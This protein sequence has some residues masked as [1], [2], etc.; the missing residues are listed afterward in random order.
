MK[1][2]RIASYLLLM[3]AILLGT[4]DLMIVFIALVNPALLIQV[5]VIACVVIYSFTSFNFLIKGIDK[6][7]VFRKRTKDLI[8]VN[9]YVSMGFALLILLQTIVIMGNPQLI[10]E[11]MK[12]AAQIQGAETA[13]FTPQQLMRM[14][15][16]VLYFMSG[17]GLILLL[18]IFYTLKLLKQNAALFADEQHQA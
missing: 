7:Q 6:Q 2:Y 9:A 1:L 15:R 11:A 3:M 8:K 17:Y 13:Q 4:I 12:Q 10:G 14:M 16:Y 18:H 5:F